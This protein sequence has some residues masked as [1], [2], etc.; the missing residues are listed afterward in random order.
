MNETYNSNLTN[1]IFEQ[2]CPFDN[3]YQ[4]NKTRILFVCSAGL[5]RSPTGAAVATK[6]GYNAR[7][8][9]SHMDYALIPLSANLINWARYIVFVNQENFDKAVTTFKGTGY[10]QDIKRKAIVLNIP[11]RYEAFH[12]QL[13]AIFENWFHDWETEK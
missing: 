10:E 6:R 11:D 12:P 8:C 9:G 13:E 4:G 2:S 5:L 3:P 7:S 1:R